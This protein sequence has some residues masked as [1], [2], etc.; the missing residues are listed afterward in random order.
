MSFI[1]EILA[2]AG[3]QPQLEAAVRGGADAVYLGAKAMNARA[4]AANFDGEQLAA[5]VSWCH[6]RG[7]KVYLTMNTLL[8]DSELPE[9][10]K[11]LSEVCRIGVDGLIVQD[12]GLASY[13]SRRAPSMRLH[14]STQCSVQIVSG[15][16]ALKK[17]GF[18]R[19]ILA[20]ELSRDELAELAAANIMELEY[21]VHGALCMSVSGQCWLSAVLGQRSGNR[22]R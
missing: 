19:A 12:M 4:S 8:F 6:T 22:G 15:V 21:F 5:A 2:P 9:A 1:P 20:R 16:R 13:I 3:G 11:L 10:E 17:L 7:V 14:A 18:C